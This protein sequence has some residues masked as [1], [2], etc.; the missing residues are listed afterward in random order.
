[1]STITQI[2]QFERDHCH[3]TQLDPSVQQEYYNLLSRFDTVRLVS[4]MNHLYDMET[5]RTLTYLEKTKKLL[6][7]QIKDEREVR[8]L[9]ELKRAKLEKKRPSE[10]VEGQ[11]PTDGKKTCYIM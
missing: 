7:Y 5:H 3:D 11:P 6:L 8:A 10:I 9:S 2:L 1:M 4:E